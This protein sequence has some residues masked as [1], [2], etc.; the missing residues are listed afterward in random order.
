M[1]NEIP[2]ETYQWASGRYLTRSLPDHWYD[3]DDKCQDQFLEDYACE[4]YEYW[5]ADDLWKEIDNLAYDV[6][7]FF[8]GGK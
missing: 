3:M 4:L 8:G 7:H 5:D 6:H 2:F 1:S